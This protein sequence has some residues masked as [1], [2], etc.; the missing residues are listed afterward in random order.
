MADRLAPNL[1][2]PDPSLAESLSRRDHTTP[3]AL[4]LLT[5]SCSRLVPHGKCRSQS[6]EKPGPVLSDERQ[7][8]LAWLRQQLQG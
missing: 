1:P 5:L 4:P 7:W 8:Q 2:L 3:M 6:Y